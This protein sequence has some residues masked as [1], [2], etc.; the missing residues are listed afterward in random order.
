MPIGTILGLVLP[1][2]SRAIGWVFD[3]F[4]KNGVSSAQGTVAGAAVIALLE[5]MGCHL[6]LAQEAVLGLVAATPG[7]LA[8]D[9]KVTGR[10]LAEAIKE[11]AR[12]QTPDGS[13]THT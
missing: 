7:I 12:P 11:A 4:W 2:V 9:A 8:T 5:G 13:Q 10:S 1:M 3:R 6:E